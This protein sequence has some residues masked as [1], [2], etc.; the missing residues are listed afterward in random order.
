MVMIMKQLLFILLA[1]CLVLLMGCRSENT[2]T[3]PT[4][5]DTPALDAT[6][7]A[8]TDKHQTKPTGVTTPAT[9]GRSDT[10]PPTQTVPSE[11]T[12][13]PTET[14]VK[15][16]NEQ[17]TT[18]TTVPPVTT[19]PPTE[20]TT[21]PTE[22]PTKPTEITEPVTQPT[23]A[24]QPTEPVLPKATAEDAGAI[25]EKLAQL[26]NSY[27]AEQGSPAAT[28][29]P[30]LSR[31]AE[32]RSVQLVTNF[33]HDT[34]DERAAATA[35]EYGTYIDPSLFGLTDDPYYTANAREAIAKTDFGGTVDQVAQYL[36]RMTRNSASHWSYVGG[37]GYTYMGVGITYEKGVWYC[38]IAVS[39]VNADE[40]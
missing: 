26:L 7:Q 10:V 20:V 19:A 25:A 36:A 40:Q 27:R 28:V 22:E 3:D 24:T 12:V 4:E 33:A 39:S 2:L 31:Y 32:Y 35:L 29:L 13:P 18:V 30:G 6:W 16:D 38:D 14:T 8:T 17:P 23:E 5:T 34:F 37:A 15:N 9:E 21:L 11:T 1:I